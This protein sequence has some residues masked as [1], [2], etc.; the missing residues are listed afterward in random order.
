MAYG[1]DF[2]DPFEAMAMAMVSHWDI[3]QLGLL[4]AEGMSAHS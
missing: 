3:T 1:I 2:T 4:I